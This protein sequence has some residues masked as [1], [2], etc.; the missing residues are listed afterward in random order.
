MMNP[1]VRPPTREKVR[2]PLTADMIEAGMDGYAK[3]PHRYKCHNL[4]TRSVMRNILEE[5][6]FH[7][8]DR[9]AP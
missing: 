1:I 6:F 4:M 2:I 5:V 8:E 3:S 7:L 9:I